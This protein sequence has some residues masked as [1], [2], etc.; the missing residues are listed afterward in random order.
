MVGLL[1]TILFT[2]KTLEMVSAWWVLALDNLYLTI[3]V[4]RRYQ[5][6]IIL[7]PSPSHQHWTAPGT[8]TTTQN[9]KEVRKYRVRSLLE[10]LLFISARSSQTPSLAGRGTGVPNI[11]LLLLIPLFPV[12]AIFYL[13]HFRSLFVTPSNCHEPFKLSSRLEL[14]CNYYQLYL[15]FSQLKLSGKNKVHSVTWA[16]LEGKYLFLFCPERGS[17]ILIRDGVMGWVGSR[18]MYCNEIRL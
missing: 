13:W 14:I 4:A 2:Y 1:V 15:R 10:L 11:E 8:T 3:L 9:T 17:T 5:E 16:R 7:L 6:P 12:L 18:K